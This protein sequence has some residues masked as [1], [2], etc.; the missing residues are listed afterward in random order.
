MFASLKSIVVIAALLSAS[1]VTPAAFAQ[2]QTGTSD[3]ILQSDTAI[4]QAAPALDGRI[5]QSDWIAPASQSQV[6]SPDLL[7]TV[8][9]PDSKFQATRAASP[10]AQ[11]PAPAAAI[12]SGMSDWTS[13]ETS[14]LPGADNTSGQTGRATV[15]P[16]AGGCQSVID[17]AA[18]SL[19]S[20]QALD[21]LQTLGQCVNLSSPG[22]ALG[23]LRGG[24]VPFRSYSR[25]RS[26]P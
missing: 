4:P 23:N 26:Q 12:Q 1:A 11:G 2:Q 19:G 17:L 6:T 16:V 14:P 13:A 25:G 15:Q 10:S 5:S 7:Q 18:Q 24:L 9:T 22:A 8:E 3:W 20:S 21:L